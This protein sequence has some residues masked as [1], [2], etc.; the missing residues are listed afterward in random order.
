MKGHLSGYPFYGRPAA[1]DWSLAGPPFEARSA[2]DAGLPRSVP[3]QEGLVVLLAHGW[4]H[5]EALTSLLACVFRVLDVLLGGDHR[6]GGHPAPTVTDP[7][8]II[9]PK[10]SS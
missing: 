2:D 1:R 7:R 5:G 4:R 10:R 9:P 6:S 3:T 8:P